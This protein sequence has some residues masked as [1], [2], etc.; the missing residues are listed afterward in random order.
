MLH[1]IGLQVEAK[2][3]RDQWIR[4][5]QAHEM[6]PS[7]LLQTAIDKSH[8]WGPTRYQPLWLAFFTTQA[9]WMRA[10]AVAP[11]AYTH[12]R[13]IALVLRENIAIH[14]AAKRVIRE[15]QFPEPYTSREDAQALVTDTKRILVEF[16]WII[17]CIENWHDLSTR[18]YNSLEG[19][20]ERAHPPQTLPKLLAFCEGFISWRDASIAMQEDLR[21]LLT[22]EWTSKFGSAP[23]E[24]VYASGCHF[25]FGSLASRKFEPSQFASAYTVLFIRKLTDAYSSCHG[26]VTRRTHQ[27]S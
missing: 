19:C 8:K 24:D 21:E 13:M 5:G 11:L 20:F 22:D 26:R 17:M 9:I 14:L 2:R 12:I 10:K 4:F 7:D 18:Y 27:S 3:V 15:C 23:A 16:R 25:I 6:L 1:L